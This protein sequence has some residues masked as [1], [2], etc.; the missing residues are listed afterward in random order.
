[1][2]QRLCAQV[3]ARLSKYPVLLSA[4]EQHGSVI[5]TNI[6]SRAG[7]LRI[8]KTFYKYYYDE[9]LAIPINPAI[10]AE[11]R[12]ALTDLFVLCFCKDT[13]DTY[14]SIPYSILFSPRPIL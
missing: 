7:V 12:P 13:S 11:Y 4:I 14:P 1:M 3:K 10:R 8:I 9:D 6:P 2:S 5:I